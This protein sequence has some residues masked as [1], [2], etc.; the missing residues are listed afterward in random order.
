MV[1]SLKDL[2]RTTYKAL[3]SAFGLLKKV[4]RDSHSPALD[5][6]VTGQIEMARN[7]RALFKLLAQKRHLN[8]YIK[9]ATSSIK[10]L[11]DRVPSE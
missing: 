3:A 6:W 9:C 2:E 8:R 5:Q 10:L 11:R 1:E 4:S 7:E